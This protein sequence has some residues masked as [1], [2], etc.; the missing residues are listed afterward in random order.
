MDRITASMLTE[1]VT[2]SGLEQLPEDQAFEHFCGYSV[3]SSHH[4]DSFASEDIV[5][6]AGADCGID[7]VAVI[8]NGYLVTEPEEI[9][10][11][12]GTNGYIDATL[13]LVQAER[14][15]NFDTAKLGHFGYGV[16]DFFK[17]EPSVAQNDALA[18]K[19]RIVGE[20]FAK[21]SKFTK[22]NPQVFLYYVTTGRWQNDANLVT[23][24]D[25]LV[26][27]LQAGNLFRNVSVRCLGAAEIQGMYRATTNAMA[28]EITFTQRVV[29]PE[30]PGV[31][32]AYLGLLPAPEFLK[33]VENTSNEIVTSVFGDNVRHWQEWNQVNLEIK[34]TL[35]DEA[36]QIYF[37]LLNNGVTI[38][39]R[40]LQ[41][42]ANKV[43]VEDYQIVN[44]CQT[45]FVLH[46]AGQN[47][48]DAV[49]V[50]V[51]MIATDD[52]NIRNAII[53]ATNRQTQV[54]D[55]QLL[56]LSDFQR[57]LEE[58]FPTFDRCRLH[59]ERR[60]KQY[61]ADP[62]IEKVRVITVRDLVR[63]F[64]SI[65]LQLPHRTTRN[66]RSLLA[67]AG[68]DIFKP[69]HRL[70]PYYV[71]A[72][73]H[74]RLEF[75]FRNQLIASELKVARYHMLLSFRWLAGLRD[76]PPMNSNE[77][78]RV[79]EGLMQTLWDEEKCKA[80][81]DEAAK[82]VYEAAG[83]DMQGRENRDQIRTEAFTDRVLELLKNL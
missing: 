44:G 12:V 75:L 80:F 2:A 22:G 72:Y 53:K 76:L 26:Q 27:A 33:L 9:D 13:I 31:E 7:C 36:Q 48:S 6:G 52:A 60:S 49:W 19:A 71:S 34:A 78:R 50:P 23:R 68:T 43:L 4:S 63:A 35:D 11:L 25:S 77:M 32:Q 42:T 45:S 47:L 56:A 10:D 66:Y 3:T 8:V 73:A 82:V 24:R 39:A 14:S 46:D 58:Y 81:F 62:N 5:V 38:V 40:R 55:E 83:G 1:F 17:D 21:S 16:L 30:L 29:L 20:L 28:T 37:P 70:E 57:K 15:E 18:A 65:F 59:Y 64:A 79:C 41:L 74:Y 51:R 67:G 69:D 54:T 61:N